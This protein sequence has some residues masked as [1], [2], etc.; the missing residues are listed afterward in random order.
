VDDFVSKN[1]GLQTLRM[2]NAMRY[3]YAHC[4]FVTYPSYNYGMSI[5]I[6]AKHVRNFVCDCVNHM[7]IYDICYLR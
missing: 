6:C 7:D 1:V 5:I 3:M 2:I 4:P